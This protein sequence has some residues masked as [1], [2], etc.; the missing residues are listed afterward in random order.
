VI[1]L[2]ILAGR[3]AAQP[4]QTVDW[5]G[6][7]NDP[8]NARYSALDQ[9][10]RENVAQ[11]KPA[12]TY[13]TNELEGRP[14]KTIECTPIVI[15]GTMY[16]TTGYLRVVALD[17]ATGAERWQFDPLKEHPSKFSPASGGGQSRLRPLVRRQARRRAADPPRHLGRAALLAGR[18]GREA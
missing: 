14:G 17:A 16:I 10:N 18:E 15:D 2:L 3:A 7:G 11:L 6:V 1:S 8:G 4:S 5:P 9:I 13:R 12:W